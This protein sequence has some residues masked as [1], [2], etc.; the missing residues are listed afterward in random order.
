[1][2]D[3]TYRNKTEFKPMAEPTST[4][5]IELRTM[6]DGRGHKEF[7]CLDDTYSPGSRIPAID[8]SFW[9]KAKIRNGDTI[10]LQTL[11]W[12]LV[13]ANPGLSIGTGT[14]IFKE[15]WL[16]NVDKIVNCDLSQYIIAT[17]PEA[18]LELKTSMFFVSLH[19]SLDG[20]VI[21]S[22]LPSSIARIM[23]PW[24]IRITNPEPLVHKANK[25][26]RRMRKEAPFWK[27]VPLFKL[28]DIFLLDRTEDE[29]TFQFLQVLS[30]L[31]FSSRLHF[32]DICSWT[33]YGAKAL[34]RP[35]ED[36]T[37]YETRQFGIDEKESSQLLINAK[38]V[39]SYKDPLLFLNSMNKDELLSML[40]KAGLETKKSLKKDALV[41]LA[42]KNCNEDV[43][44]LSK[45]NFYA[46]IAKEFAQAAQTTFNR[47][48]NTIEIYRLLLGF[49]IS[50]EEL[51]YSGSTSD[52]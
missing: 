51:S 16:A 40:A 46:T 13:K 36:M 42:L 3:T 8:F 35:I 43:E 4:A 31:P 19:S 45:S 47:N 6:V 48:Y 21:S 11:L 1:M 14:D 17:N 50:K 37:T 12:E 33:D 7:F 34:S 41:D 24:Y 30:S 10:A 52:D 26:I 2:K 39:K 44:E 22:T 5:I 32:F 38:L 27:D 28:E 15:E 25:F 49:S 9:V 23:F 20:F 18:F 29:S